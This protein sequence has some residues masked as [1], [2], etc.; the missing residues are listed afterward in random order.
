[1][2]SDAGAEDAVGGRG[3]FIPGALFKIADGDGV[4]MP[5]FGGAEAGVVGAFPP[6]DEF[7]GP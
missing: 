4:G 1:M 3:G 7:G 6:C 5:E 2:G